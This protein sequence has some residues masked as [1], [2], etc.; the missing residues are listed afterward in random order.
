VL[1]PVIFIPGHRDG[2]PEPWPTYRWLQREPPHIEEAR[3][4]ASM[5]VKEVFRVADLVDRNR[6]L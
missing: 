2:T 6:S 5:M 1:R 3:E 4:A